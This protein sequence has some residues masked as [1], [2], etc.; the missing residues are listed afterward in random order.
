[1]PRISSNSIPGVSPAGSGGSQETSSVPTS[2]RTPVSR[3]NSSVFESLP[4]RPQSASGEVGMSNRRGTGLAA[5]L[6]TA[7]VDLGPA[8]SSLNLDSGRLPA[9]ANNSLH[10]SEVIASLP[11]FESSQTDLGRDITLPEGSLASRPMIDKLGRAIQ[12]GQITHEGFKKLPD[13]WK[14]AM[15][16]ANV[17]SIIEKNPHRYASDSDKQLLRGVSEFLNS[18]QVEQAPPGENLFPNGAVPLSN[19]AG[20][21]RFEA[22]QR[23]SAAG[24]EAENHIAAAQAQHAPAA[25]AEAAPVPETPAE[26]Q[27]RAVNDPASFL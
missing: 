25:E 1:M 4:P 16:G 21:D 7:P 22:R 23:V 15:L 13:D 2:P 17:D 18:E 24:R 3:T 6:R 9:T 20:S 5:L 27:A 10:H 11:N 8:S 14:S 12:A 19:T 26:V